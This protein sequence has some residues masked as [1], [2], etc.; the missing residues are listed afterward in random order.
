M[1]NPQEKRSKVESSGERSVAIGENAIGNI[2]KTGNETHNHYP[3]NP[4]V[5]NVLTSKIESLSSDLSKE[6]A[7]KLEKLREEFREGDV[8][9]S[10][11]N[12]L[13]LKNSQNWREF[14]NPLQVSILSALASMVLVTKGKEGVSEAKEFVKQ[15][16]EIE[17][18][19]KDINILSRI[20]I[21]EEG[22]EAVVD[23]LSEYKDTESY[24][25]WLSCLLNLSNYRDVINSLENPPKN[26]ELNAESHRLYSLALLA[27]KNINQAL[28]EIQKAVAE[29]PNWQYIR[30]SSAIIKYFSAISPTAL[31]AYLVQYP[32]PV[33]QTW[34]KIDDESQQN[35]RDAAGEFQ[36]L[37]NRFESSSREYKELNSW[38]FACLANLMNKHEETIK[39]GNELLI[40]DPANFQIISWFLLRRYEFDHLKSLKLLKQKEEGNSVNIED[41]LALIGIYLNFERASDALNLINKRKEIFTSSGETD[42]WKY[43][44]GQ[45]LASNGEIDKALLEVEKITDRNFK[46]PLK[47][48]VL[49]QKSKKE[50]DWQS[51][52]QFLE[53]DYKKNKDSTSFLSLFETKIQ[54]AKDEDFVVENA[55]LYCDLME[56]AASVNFVV[57][58]LWK[59]ERPEK[60]LELLNSKNLLFPQNEL[61]SHLRRLKIH[62]LIKTSDIKN[63][64]VEAENLLEDKNNVE[65]IALLMDVYLSKGDL[66]ALQ[67]ISKKLLQ[68]PDVNAEDLLRAAHLVQIKDN[69]LAIK[70]WTKAVE[71]GIPDNADLVVFANSIASKLG[72][73]SQNR[74]LMK[75]MMQQAHRNQGPVKFMSFR[76]ALKLMQKNSKISREFDQKYGKGEIPLHILSTKKNITLAEIFNRT[77]DRNRESS[78]IHNRPRLFIRHGARI[79]PPKENFVEAK[80]WKLYLDIT[81]L[82]LANKIGI[83][84]QMENLFSPLKIS[85][86]IITALIEQKDKLKP[87]Q[88][89]QLDSSKLIVDLY[90]R[91]KFQ[92]L[93]TQASEESLKYIYSLLNDKKTEK[94]RK[95]LRR[96]RNRSKGKKK[97]VIFANAERLEQQLGDRLDT[98][99]QAVNAKGYSVGF[100]PLN[101]Y[102]SKDF[103]KLKLP[104]ILDVQIIN[105]RSI[106][107]SLKGK[108][109]ISETKYKDAIRSLGHEGNLLSKV[110]PLINSKL[111]LMSGVDSV[112]AKADILEDICENFEVILPKRD[113][114]EAQNEIQ[115]FKELA[116]VG[117]K[118]EK[119]LNRINDGLDEGIYEFIS[120]SE[121]RLKKE[122]KAPRN[123]S[124]NIKSTLDLFLFKPEEWNVVSIDDRN[125]T[126]H[127]IR[128]EN[129]KVVPIIGINEI[130]L[131]LWQNGKIDSQKYY[132]L[133]LELRKSNYRYIPIKEDEINFHLNQARIENGRIIE[134][135]ALSVLRKYHSSCFLDT[136]FI[137]LLDNNPFSES[138]FLIQ[139]I[140]SINYAIAEIWKEKDSKIEIATAKADWIIENLYTGHFGCNHFNNQSLQNNVEYNS[141]DVIAFDMCNLIMHGLLLDD[142][143][144]EPD[145]VSNRIFYYDWLIDK[146][147]STRLISTSKV[148]EKTAELIKERLLIPTKQ[149][150]GSEQEKS[151]ARFMMGKFYV[152]LPE[153]ITR[154]IKLD[155][156]TISWLGVQIGSFVSVSNFTFDYDEYWNAVKEVLVSNKSHKI[157]DKE[158]GNEYT[159][160]RGEDKEKNGKQFFPMIKVSDSEGNQLPNIEDPSFS[161]FSTNREIRLGSIENLRSWFDCDDENFKERA[162]EIVD[163]KDSKKCM[164]EL[165]DVASNSISMFYNQLDGKL[166]KQE[167]IFW[168]DLLPPSANNL[169]GAYRLPKQINNETDFTSFWDK[170]AE[171]LIKE[172]ELQSIIVK[173][174]H[175]PIL[176]PDA[177]LDNFL[178]LEFEEKIKTL[179]TLSKPWT[180]PI[181]LLHAINLSVRS[182]D[183]EDEQISN[184]AKELV[185]RLYNSEEFK[186]DFEA[187]RAYLNFVKD[188][189]YFWDEIVDWSPELKLFI[190]W[191]H[192]GVLYNTFRA[193]GMSS[194]NI[195][196]SLTNRRDNL[197]LE[198]LIRDS[199]LWNDCSHPNRTNRIKF[200]T[201]AIAK[202]LEGSNLQTIRDFGIDKLIRNEVFI[203]QKDNTQLSS[204][205]LLS[206]PLLNSNL[207]GSVFGG[208]HLDILAQFIEEND[209]IENL[210]SVNLKQTVIDGLN[211]L[212]NN[213][214][215]LVKWLLIHLIAP[216]IPIYQ[217]LKSECARA[218]RNFN[219]EDLLEETINS[220]SSVLLSP[221][222]QSAY[223]NNKELRD[224]FRGKIIELLIHLTKDES[225]EIDLREISTLME[226][227]FSISYHP[228]NSIKSV[229][230]F[231][232]LLD[233]IVINW[234]DFHTKVGFVFKDTMW[235]ISPEQSKNWAETT[236]KIRTQMS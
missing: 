230:E 147:L 178:D 160:S 204:Y 96:R 93:E 25:L 130:L 217:D 102:G 172:E 176:F 173:F 21:Y 113:L 101:C 15:A 162:T 27:T 219:F 43:W 191:A 222:E 208:N 33:L 124:Q 114:E 81:S 137:Q 229:K 140:E 169:L 139:A 66:T 62:C 38:Y 80:N 37:I 16:T 179:E 40:E 151:F 171:T 3:L 123:L 184:I 122:D 166:R 231:V 49:Y 135:E 104:E 5:Q 203:T 44:Y 218:L 74:D 154:K 202:L 132:S 108:N 90:N 86:H 109:R 144:L 22:F 95:N 77:A 18:S 65:N 134:T 210:D 153:V 228:N 110:S 71:V 177:L 64:V 111:Y 48:A 8:N 73:E 60:C 107:E 207:L 118:L 187:F 76:Q 170:S 50:D 131:A 1:K 42:L 39:F 67:V 183:I 84:D 120:I 105:C 57:E 58:A 88:K 32:R 106:L 206:D 190:I 194:E 156:E 174:S 9:K 211:D 234:E 233:D 165:L 216:D 30:F 119:L 31:P 221:T 52:I 138:P 198:K 196:S 182:S 85:R 232:S 34:V 212:N 192:A 117:N 69:N 23:E 128:Q 189:V 227:A 126:K 97:K 6:I 125:L 235:N 20:K 99:A 195:V 127:S 41:L 164:T 225:K 56:T 82:L 185:N 70:F 214:S 205:S 115:H 91:D 87:H 142:N 103:A 24:N 133:V 148:L 59:F 68:H 89:S 28:V 213:S 201:H 193:V 186:Q 197:H 36:N 181:Q 10:F 209:N 61:P 141:V 26:I 188:E 45:I 175:L 200:L 72:L 167:K 180:S 112:L 75:Q 2:I 224:K 145:S 220:P 129:Q 223:L 14:E 53:D 199:A 161:M 116:E 215:D 94:R 19:F 29:K 7:A 236:L 83:L 11:E 168:T 78:E 46:T 63:A 98:I 146:I 136:D 149:Q 17:K 158:N 226:A 155:S 92:V 143:L 13:S 150:F 100:L 163:I 79:L 4:I 35:L 12:I 157:K 47:T 159:F 152:D 54:N 55:K 51:L 121:D